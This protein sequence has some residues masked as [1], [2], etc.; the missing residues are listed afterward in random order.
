LNQVLTK[1]KS[2]KLHSFKGW[3]HSVFKK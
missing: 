2:D 1:E 3:I